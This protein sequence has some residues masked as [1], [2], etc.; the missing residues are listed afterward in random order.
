MKNSGIIIRL[1]D[2]R[3]VIVYDRQP[4]A[5]EKGK[6]ILNLV[7]ENHNLIKGEDGKPKVIMK[8]IHVYNEEMQVATLIGYVD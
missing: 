5:K 8:D 7:D 6:I 3:M 4:L 2:N 1:P